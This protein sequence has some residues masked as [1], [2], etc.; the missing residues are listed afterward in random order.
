[1]GDACFAAKQARSF[2]NSARLINGWLC[3]RFKDEVRLAND[4]NRLSLEDGSGNLHSQ[5]KWIF[6]LT[7]AWMPGTG[8]AMTRRPRRNH[9]PAFKAKVALAA[10]RGELTLENDFLAEALGKAKLLGGKDDRPR[11][12]IVGRTPGEASRLQPWQRLL[13][14]SPNS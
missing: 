10:I 11:P 14:A 8:G 1:M 13:P 5:D 7:L 3:G 9:N 12:Q 4:T 6:R 2:D